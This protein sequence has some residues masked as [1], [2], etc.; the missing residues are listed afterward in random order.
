MNEFERTVR[1]SHDPEANAAYIDLRHA[2][3]ST[4]YPTQIVGEDERLAATV[5]LD[6]TADGLLGGIEV[7]G[8]SPLLDGLLPEMDSRERS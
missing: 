7:V 2:D 5:V 8:V 4:H 1:I 6:L 3:E